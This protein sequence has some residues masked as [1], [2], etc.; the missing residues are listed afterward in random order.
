MYFFIIINKFTNHA[1]LNHTNLTNLLKQLGLEDLLNRML[2]M[3][4]SMADKNGTKT[5]MSLERNE[6]GLINSILMVDYK[7]ELRMEWSKSNRKQ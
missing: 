1:T 2:Q 5:I 7:N 6:V 4:G 3:F